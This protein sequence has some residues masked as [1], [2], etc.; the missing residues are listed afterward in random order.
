MVESAVLIHEY[1]FGNAL[2]GIGGIVGLPMAEDVER[3]FDLYQGTVIVS[4]IGDSAFFAYDA[5]V[6][7]VVQD[8]LIGERSFGIF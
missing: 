3:I 4:G 2:S 1:L 5:D 8:A 6:A 7:V